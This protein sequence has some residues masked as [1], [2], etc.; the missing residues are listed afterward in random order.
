MDSSG[1]SLIRS[2]ELEGASCQAFW[3]RLTHVRGGVLFDPKWVSAEPKREARAPGRFVSSGID[4]KAKGFNCV[5]KVGRLHA[6]GGERLQDRGML[7]WK[8]K[9]KSQRYNANRFTI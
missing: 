3:N 1:L 2:P 8:S 7:R 6:G 4:F 9:M 5:I